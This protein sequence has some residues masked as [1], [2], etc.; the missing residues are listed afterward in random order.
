MYPGTLICLCQDFELS[1]F[2]ML[3]VSVESLVTLRSKWHPTPIVV[4]SSMPTQTRSRPS[5]TLPISQLA[6]LGKKLF[7]GEHMPPFPFSYASPITFPASVCPFFVL[8]FHSPSPL[9]LSYRYPYFLVTAPSSRHRPVFLSLPTSPSPPLVVRLPADSA[10]SLHAANMRLVNRSGSDSLI[11]FSLLGLFNSTD[12][13]TD[14]YVLF[15][16]TRRQSHPPIQFTQRKDRVKT[17]S[18][19]KWLVCLSAGSCPIP[20]KYTT[21]IVDILYRVNLV[22]CDDVKQ[23]SLDESLS[24]PLA[25]LWSKPLR[26]F[27]LYNPGP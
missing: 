9:L 27:C 6:T 26:R 1:S 2:E 15:K 23:P 16:R 21:F 18:A 7:M 19:V 17:L 22:R 20:L 24:Q 12:G 8:P 25:N 13:A 5:S 3:R 11:L 14:E 4:L 10:Q